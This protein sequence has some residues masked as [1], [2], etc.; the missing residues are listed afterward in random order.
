MAWWNRAR[1]GD[2]VLCLGHPQPVSG[3]EKTGDTPKAGERHLINGIA[4]FPVIP[5][6]EGCTAYLFLEGFDHA[7]GAGNFEP[8][9]PAGLF[10][11]TRIWL[12][13]KGAA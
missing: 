10:Q 1:I 12:F 5:D 2:E 9:R 8:V 7:Y 3:A 13:G 6:G 4:D 11:R